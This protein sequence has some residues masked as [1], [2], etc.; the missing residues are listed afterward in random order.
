MPTAL[1]TGVDGQDGSYLADYLLKRDYKVYG[2]IRSRTGIDFDNASLYFPNISHL[3]KENKFIPLFG[4]LLDK[5]SLKYVLEIAQPDEVYNLAAQSHVKIS[6]TQKE[7]TW[8]TNALGVVSLLE[9]LLHQF[10]QTRIYQASTSEMFGNAPAPQNENTPLDPVSPYGHSKLHAHNAIDSY[11][12]KGL[13]AVAGI[14]FNHESP[15]RGISFVTRKITHSMARIKLGLQDQFELGNLDAKRDWG[16]A[17]DYVKAMH[18][19]LRQKTPKNYVI[20][21]GET[22]T[23]REF[24][25]ASAE[26]LSIPLEWKGEGQH[27][28]G[29]SEGKTIITINPAFYRAQEIHQLHGDSTLARKELNWKPEVSFTQLVEMMAK[30]D[31][32]ALIKQ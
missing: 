4:D 13:F 3:H 28:I 32:D 30:A 6:E 5:G 19:M 27:E 31:Y 8:N 9:L 26:S 24:I 29:I 25:E 12:S 15:R 16:F 21:S 22:H 1:I 23:V 7:L 2:L 17:G 18:L 10:P 20:S 11:R 14:L